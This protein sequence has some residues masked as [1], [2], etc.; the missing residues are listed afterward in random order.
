MGI[1]LDHKLD[2]DIFLPH[3][4]LLSTPIILNPHL[5]P[6]LSAV[7]D[8]SH[9]LLPIREGRVYLFVNY[10]SM[11]FQDAW[12]KGFSISQHSTFS[13]VFSGQNA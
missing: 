3:G 2:P 9:Y 1:Y 8:L 7:I 10:S 4:S 13:F 5:V 11:D 12:W 6:P